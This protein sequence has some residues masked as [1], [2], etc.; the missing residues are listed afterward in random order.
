MDQELEDS[1]NVELAF[2]PDSGLQTTED[3]KFLERIAGVYLRYEA[4]YQRVKAAADSMLRAI[5]NKLQGIQV[6]CFPRVREILSARIAESAAR[7]KGTPA[8]FVQTLKGRLGLRTIPGRLT[9]KEPESVVRAWMEGKIPTDCVETRQVV[10][11]DKVAS[12]VKLTGDIPDGVEQTEPREVLYV[13]AA[14]NQE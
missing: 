14:F 7:G 9:I 13:K 5:E 8:K 12:Y 10:S 4:E 2:E 1:I 11:S 3:D 6:V